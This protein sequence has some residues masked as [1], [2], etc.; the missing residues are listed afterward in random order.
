MKRREFL[1]GAMSAGV[2][3]QSGPRFVGITVMPEYVQSEGVEGVLRNLRRAGATAVATSPYVMAA[4]ETAASQREPPIDAG[5]GAVR[6]LDRPLWGKRELRVV[7]APSFAPDPE[8]YR[9][10]RFQPAPPVEL[11]R[12]QGAVVGQFVRAA[13]ARGLKVYLQIQAAT[14]LDTVF[15]S[16][17]RTLT[18]NRDCQMAGSRRAASRTMAASLHPTSGGTLKALIRDLC[19]QYPE[20]DGIRVDWLEYPPYFLDD[21]FLDFSRPARD[22]AGRLGI[23]FERM[24]EDAAQAYS[25]LYGRLTDRDLASVLDGDGGMYAVL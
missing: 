1:A 19:R 14:R 6:L 24:R 7:T 11:T 18:P 8:L 17:V 5:A 15:S 12:T 4:S 20:I 3:A 23:G 13:K 16:V 25:Y 9:G 10:L 2:R 21:A 22:A